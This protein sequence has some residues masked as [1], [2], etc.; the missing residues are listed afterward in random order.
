MIIL[1]GIPMMQGGPSAWQGQFREGML[2]TL[3][4]LDENVTGKLEFAVVKNTG[5]PSF[6]LESRKMIAGNN[7]KDLA[8]QINKHIA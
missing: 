4:V 1:V 5:Q 3:P 8:Q 7:L 6:S 2:Q